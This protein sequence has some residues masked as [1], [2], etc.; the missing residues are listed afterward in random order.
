MP[1]SASAA[2]EEATHEEVERPLI[3]VDGTVQVLGWGRP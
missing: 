1:T 3:E 2:D